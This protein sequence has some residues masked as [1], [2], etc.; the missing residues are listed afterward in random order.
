VLS[1]GHGALFCLAH[2]HFQVVLGIIVIILN[3]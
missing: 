1:M 2:H 3:I